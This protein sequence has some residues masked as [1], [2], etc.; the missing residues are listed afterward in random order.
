MPDLGPFL[1]FFGVSSTDHDREE[2]LNR[3]FELEHFSNVV[4]LDLA[5][6]LEPG[7]YLLRGLPDEANKRGWTVGQGGG[8]PT[9]HLSDDGL[10]ELRDWMGQRDRWVQP[11]AR[12]PPS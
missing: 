3:R 12:P 6:P 7:Q 11:E 1:L 4:T 9:G 8:H 2:R 10:E 5:S